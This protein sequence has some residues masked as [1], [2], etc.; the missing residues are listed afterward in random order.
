MI[1]TRDQ[2]PIRQFGFLPHAILPLS[3]SLSQNNSTTQLYIMSYLLAHPP[4]ARA[5]GNSL[6]LVVLCDAHGGFK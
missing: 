1:I 5:I 3:L 6:S 4:V 2:I